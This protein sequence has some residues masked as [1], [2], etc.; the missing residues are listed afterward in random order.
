MKKLQVALAL[1]LASC[2]HHSSARAD[3]QG[4]MMRAL[5]SKYSASVVTLQLVLKTAAASG[6]QQA[7]LEAGGIVIDPSGLIATTNT[8]IDPTSMYAS[9]MGEEYARGMAT[10]V[11]NMKIVLASGEEIP[12]R[13]V[14]R[15][16][17]RNLAIV[18]PLQ[19]LARPLTSVNFKGNNTS[20]LG[21]VVYFLGRLGKA[22]SRQPQITSQR[23]VGLVEKPRK[24]YV[25]D[26]SAYSYLG[27]VVF[28]EQGQ[29]LGLLSMKMTTVGRSMTGSD[30]ILAIVIPTSDV[31][32]V[33]LQAPQ[34]KD[35]HERKA[36][37]AVK[38]PAVKAPVKGVPVKPGVPG[39]KSR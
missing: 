27:D 5:T 28:N 36:K 8:A 10:S 16:K 4:D 11:V 23:V 6:G 12:A 32:E 33:A 34:A 37:P 26:S 24:F 35:V 20:R 39:A 30:S 21:D 17:D 3:A 13:V 9:M 25:L 1:A 18:R 31:W 38:A 29:P 15:D 2:T 22:G 19:R 7:K 14:L